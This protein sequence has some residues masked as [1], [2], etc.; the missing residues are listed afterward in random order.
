MTA[1]SAAASTVGPRRV[2][3]IALPVVLSNVTVP[4]QGAI[5][6]AVV[7]TAIVFAWLVSRPTGAIAPLV[8]W[9]VGL[10]LGARL[11]PSA[12]EASAV[13][14]TVAER[15]LAIVAPIAAAFI[16]MATP[17]VDAFD[18]WLV[19]VVAIV[20]G[21]IKATGLMLGSRLMAGRR[22]I[23]GLA[24]GTAGAAGGIVPLGIA[25]TLYAGGM[26][27]AALFVAQVVAVGLG[28]LLAGPLLAVVAR[29]QATMQEGTSARRH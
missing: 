15:V 1:F 19:L 16:G 5:D 7:L 22:W 3:A 23:E 4:L 17:L 25:W 9:L 28:G 2:L 10:V 14:P 27:D 13:G 24:L 26:I 8:A 29:M 12:S 18:L 6:T 20:A 21:D 11:V